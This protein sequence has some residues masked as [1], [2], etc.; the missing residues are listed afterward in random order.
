M[1]RQARTLV[2]IVFLVVLA[3]LALGFQSI[4]VGAFQ[5][6]GDTVLGLS[7][8]LDLQGGS[9]LVYR[10]V[11]EEPPTEDDMEGLRRII[12]R[13]VNAS[14]LGEP[15]IQLL[16]E[17]R[18]LIQLPGVQDTARAKDIIGETAR[19][20]FKQ[21]SLDVPR[22]LEE[23]S[24]DDVVGV[25]LMTLRELDAEK[26]A[27][28]FGTSSLPGLA[29]TSTALAATSTEAAATT[30][31][32][33]TSTVPSPAEDAIPVL[34]IEFTEQ[35]AERFETVVQ[36]LQASLD[37]LPGTGDIYPNVLTI[38]A[39]DDPL[40]AVRVP[41]QTFVRAST[42]GVVPLPGDPNIERIRGTNEFSFN[43]Q[44]SVRDM[45]EALD[46]FASQPEVTFGEILG[47]LDE[48]VN[49]TGDDLA[50][51]YPGQHAG[52][53]VPIVNI[54]FSSEGARKFGEIT[55]DIAGTS[56]LLAIVL[57]NEELIAPTVQQP[58]LG[59]SAFIQGRDFTI[60]RVRDIALLLESGRLPIPID[61][62]E[63]RD[64]DAILGADSL[65]KSGV[66]GMV[67]L[68]LVLLFM[69]LY[70]RV[71]GLVA[72]VAL[73][74]YAVLVLA[75][76]KMLPVTLTLSG[77][78]A[79]IL[80]VGMA[81]DANILIFERMKDELRAGRTL[82]SAVNIGFNRAW[83]AIRDGNVSTLITCAILF[84]FSDTLGTTVV[85]GFA[86]SLAI[87]VGTSMFSA[88]IVSRTFLRLMAATPVSRRLGWFVPAGGSQL[89]Q[90]QP[91]MQ[92]A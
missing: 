11:A 59:G 49:L 9:H 33:A 1:R 36:R 40:Q 44:A 84:W 23:I 87:G 58:I 19:L 70:Y 69:V 80:S 76:F 45:A 2:I 86:V 22:D 57:D 71:P 48:D 46:R 12:E 42:I 56:D 24:A 83:P 60:D 7:L 41:Y 79:V 47:K 89:P 92:A 21:R 3:G 8:G 63:E 52:S 75:I 32:A 26:S 10:A 62:I 35:A 51:A 14:G 91:G 25:R 64:V 65:A 68:A 37:P 50:R 78:A 27:L 17:D 55:T 30:A 39:E 31:A 34:V 66:A 13:R 16:G 67:G 18:I 15:I 38:G 72:A 81:V 77:V 20:E 54:E 90:R 88:I 82:L 5:R 4:D 6:G 74:I 53:G 73:V 29:E 61:I 43:L 85:Q 28:T